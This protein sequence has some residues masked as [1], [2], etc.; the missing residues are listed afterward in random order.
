MKKKNVYILWR[1]K[2]FLHLESIGKSRSAQDGGNKRAE[3]MRKIEI[4]MELLFMRRTLHVSVCVYV[5]RLFEE[6]K[7]N[8]VSTYIKC[9]KNCNS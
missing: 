7:K 5:V 1:E 2:C 4:K 6:E 8:S 9:N 3:G